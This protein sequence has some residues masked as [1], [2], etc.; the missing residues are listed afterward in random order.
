L[1]QKLQWLREYPREAR[2][3][4]QAARERVL[5]KFTWPRVVRRCLEIYKA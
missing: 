3:M 2:A 4:G 1:S 5:E